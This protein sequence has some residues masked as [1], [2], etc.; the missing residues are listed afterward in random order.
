[1]YHDFIRLAFRFSGSKKETIDCIAWYHTYLKI[2][3]DSY[4]DWENR[5]LMMQVDPESFSEK[6]WN[7][8]HQIDKEREV[9]LEELE[10]KLKTQLNMNPALQ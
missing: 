6:I 2:W 10:R 9:M 1:M 4:A 3:L 5:R 8:W 7:E